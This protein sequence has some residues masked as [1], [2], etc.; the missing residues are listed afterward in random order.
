[1]A[2][3]MSTGTPL[4]AGTSARAESRGR[5]LVAP[6]LLLIALAAM[7]A[8]MAG[9]EVVAVSQSRAL[10]SHTRDVIEA[11]QNLFAR[12]QDVES[13]Q[14]GYLLSGDPRLLEHYDTARATIPATSS[15]WSTATRNRWRESID[16]S[17]RSICA[18]R[19]R[20]AESTY[21]APRAVTRP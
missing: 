18:W 14:R 16:W 12:V 17:G 19:S 4:G 7:T 15:V 1:M 10:V 21:T 20:N 8:F 11:T 9:N 2:A 5:T 3:R 13:G 6:V